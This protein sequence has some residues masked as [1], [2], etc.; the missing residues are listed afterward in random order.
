MRS[1][2]RSLVPEMETNDARDYRPMGNEILHGY[3]VGTQV[4]KQKPGSSTR[5]WVEFC[6]WVLEKR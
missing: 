2:E 6:K 1:W 4:E 3:S 5:L